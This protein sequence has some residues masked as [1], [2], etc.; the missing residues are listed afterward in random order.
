[1]KGFN[2]GRVRK[3][4]GNVGGRSCP[5]TPQKP[6]TTSRSDKVGGSAGGSA[7]GSLPTTPRKNVSTDLFA[8]PGKFVSVSAVQRKLIMS[9]TS[10]GPGAGLGAAPDPGHVAVAFGLSGLAVA[11]AV[12]GATGGIGGAHPRTRDGKYEMLIY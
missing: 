4:G 7:G 2:L 3:T 9:D 10:A 1:M 12:P 6:S 8:S 11:A 5:T